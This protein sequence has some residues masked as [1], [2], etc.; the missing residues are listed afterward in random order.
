M[1]FSGIANSLYTITGSNRKAKI[2]V[3]DKRL[4]VQEPVIPKPTVH[5]G[6][7]NPVPAGNIPGGDAVKDLGSKAASAATSA[8]T[9]KVQSVANNVVEKLPGMNE[10]PGGDY[11]KCFTVQFNPASLNIS[12]VSGGSY[13]MFDFGGDGKSAKT[14]PLRPNLSLNVVLIFDQ[15]D[16]VNSFPMDSIDY[17]L[18]SGLQ[19]TLKAV[20]NITTSLPISV[21]AAT[22]GFVGVLTNPYTKLVC[23]EWGRLRYKGVIKN[24]NANYKLFDVLGRP[25]RSEVALSIYLADEDIKKAGGKSNLG[26][27]KEAYD[28][29]FMDAAD[30][31]EV[32]VKRGK[33]IASLIQG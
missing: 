1:D 9:D 33:Q 18:S 19:K 30:G 10:G 26:V 28:A 22:E 3:A 5:P 17:S 13:E 32:A 29:A 4:K 16:L 12:G 31:Y 20:T 15:M 2:Y 14:T 24:V 27:W 23:F 8:V 7:V 21:Q 11:N 6:T 25:V